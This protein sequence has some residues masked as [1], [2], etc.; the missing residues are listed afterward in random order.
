MFICNF[1]VDNQNINK[2]NHSNNNSK[3]SGN[4]WIV[5]V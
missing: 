2:N 1:M 4:A 5:A 3:F